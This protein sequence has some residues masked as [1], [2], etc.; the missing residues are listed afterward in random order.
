MGVLGALE[1]KGVDWRGGAKSQEVGASER[2]SGHTRAA[3]GAATV[4]LA[5]ESHPEELMRLS[6]AASAANDALGFLER[7]QIS[8]KCPYQLAVRLTRE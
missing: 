1:V 6:G 3:L 8:F 2:A 5:G 7:V 4:L